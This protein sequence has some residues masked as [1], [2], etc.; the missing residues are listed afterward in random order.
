MLE[1]E[2]KPEHVFHLLSQ[3]KLPLPDLLQKTGGRVVSYWNETG[4]SKKF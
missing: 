1:R 3:A 2:L 4:K